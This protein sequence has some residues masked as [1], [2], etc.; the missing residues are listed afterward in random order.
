MFELIALM[1]WIT[2]TGVAAVG[3]FVAVRR[4][5]S[6]RLRYVDA[7]RSPLAPWLAGIGA[8][9][10]AV[11]VVWLLPVVGAGT[12]LAFGVGVGTGVVSGRRQFR[13][14]PGS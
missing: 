14:L 9:L 1:L 11:P 5:V 2:V 4:F 10:L 3:G 7:V 12:A 13:R 6:R 8:V